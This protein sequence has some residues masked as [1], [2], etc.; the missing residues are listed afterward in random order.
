MDFLCSQ[1]KI[2]VDGWDGAR[3]GSLTGWVGLG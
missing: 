2:W 3:E 1:S